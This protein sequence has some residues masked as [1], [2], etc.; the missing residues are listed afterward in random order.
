M[1]NFLLLKADR[2]KEMQKKLVEEERKEQE[3]LDEA[4]RQSEEEE[5]KRI[6]AEKEANRYVFWKSYVGLLFYE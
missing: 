5:Q 6:E 1:Q 3:R 2:E 4:I